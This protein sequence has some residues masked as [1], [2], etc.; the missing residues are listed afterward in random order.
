[1]TEHDPKQVLDRNIT[2][3][4]TRDI[5]GYLANQQPDVQFVLPGG[6]TLQGR[7]QLRDYV[8]AQWAAFP[9]G[10]LKFGARVF[11]DDAAA[12]EVVFTGTHTG[13]MATP[14]GPIPPTGKTVTLHTASIL[15]IKDGLIA[16]EHVYM[17]QLELMGQLSP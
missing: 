3:I 5:E 13:P 1:V 8:E 10:T 17:D 4:N 12:V 16:S 2:A 15:S 14:D 11:G 9:D 6:V 7:D